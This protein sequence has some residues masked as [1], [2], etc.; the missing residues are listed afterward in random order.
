MVNIPSPKGEKKVW[1][2]SAEVEKKGCVS[3]FQSFQAPP[4]DHVRFTLVLTK[5][6]ELDP[7]A[8]ILCSLKNFK[9]PQ[10][11]L[12]C[13]FSVSHTVDC[14]GAQS[15][16]KCVRSGG[17][18]SRLIIFCIE[19]GWAEMLNPE[20]IVEDSAVLSGR[21]SGEHNNKLADCWNSPLMRTSTTSVECVVLCFVCGG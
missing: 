10:C 9:E 3:H 19:N 20:Q 17:G 1:F 14:R 8:G 16:Q 11:F 2:P 13:F 7:P 18:S 21:R 12:L 15:A 5:V 4:S 6:L